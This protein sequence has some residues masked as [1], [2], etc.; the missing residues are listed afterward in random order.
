MGGMNAE[1]K[2]AGMRGEEVLVNVLI[3]FK[4]V[5]NLIVS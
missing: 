5:L 4:E 1:M 3:F 2:K